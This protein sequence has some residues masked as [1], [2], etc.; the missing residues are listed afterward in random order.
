MFLCFYAIIYIVVITKTGD[1]VR[2]VNSNKK[3]ISKW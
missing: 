1:K 3:V 2:K